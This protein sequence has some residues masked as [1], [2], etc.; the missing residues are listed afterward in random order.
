MLFN[1]V[2]GD[3]VKGRRKGEEEKH[4]QR[5]GEGDKQS[6]TPLLAR[7]LFLVPDRM[8]KSRPRW[9]LRTRKAK[10]R[11]LRSCGMAVLSG[12]SVSWMVVGGTQE[13]RPFRGITLKPPSSESACTKH[14]QGMKH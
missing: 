7:W 1:L 13:G 6:R 8:S 5:H 3:S 11:G 4:Y 10:R 2:G 9:S 12:W 14:S